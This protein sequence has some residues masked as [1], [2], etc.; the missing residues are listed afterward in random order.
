[1][2]KNINTKLWNVLKKR[3]QTKNHCSVK[4][5]NQMNERRFLHSASSFCIIITNNI[6]YTSL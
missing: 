6:F 1:M 3:K 5:I 2:T 4:T